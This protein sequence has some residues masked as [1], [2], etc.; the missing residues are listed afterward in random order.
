MRHDRKKSGFEAND[1]CHDKGLFGDVILEFC[2]PSRWKELSKETSSKI[3]PGG[4]GSCRKTY[5]GLKTKQKRL[6]R[7]GGSE[8]S[9]SA[10]ADNDWYEV[11]EVA[12]N[13]WYEVAEVAANDWYE[14]S[15]D[16]WESATCDDANKHIDKFLTVTQSMEQNGVPHDV[17]RL[18]LFTYSLT[19]HATS[20]FDH[21]PKNSIHSWEEMVTKFLSKY[22]PPSMVTKLR[23]DIS[24]FQ[25]LPDESLFESWERYKLLIDRCPNHNMLPSLNRYIL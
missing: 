8:V 1:R 5:K 18:C 12:A 7:D 11:A 13:D 15:A 9:L 22:F 20:W 6:P 14:V 4:D 19:H 2:S 3:L 10:G 25:Q 17:M 21:L 24:N 16:Q 23:N